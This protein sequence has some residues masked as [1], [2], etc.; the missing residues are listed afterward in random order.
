MGF[1]FAGAVTTSADASLVIRADQSVAV[2]NTS[3]AVFNTFA[4]SGVGNFGDFGISG[5]VPIEE[6]VRIRFRLKL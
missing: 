4:C 3:F 2:S 1:V 5:S 6:V